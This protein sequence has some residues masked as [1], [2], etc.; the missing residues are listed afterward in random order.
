MF[1]IQ[2]CIKNSFNNNQGFYSI[3][4]KNL[5]YIKDK[6]FISVN[7]YYEEELWFN[8]NVRNTI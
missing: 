4:L 6:P 3:K 8:I 5:N 7:M 2:K 1:S